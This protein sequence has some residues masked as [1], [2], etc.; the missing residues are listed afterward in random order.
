MSS[1]R[2]GKTSTHN[3]KTRITTIDTNKLHIYDPTYLAIAIKI[4]IFTKP[5]IIINIK[6]TQ[7]IIIAHLIS[8]T[9]LTAKYRILAKSR[10]LL[11]C[12]T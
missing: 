2:G 8:R 5:K 12:V 7:K 1:T 11:I 10:V 4:T 9:L 3:L 6:L